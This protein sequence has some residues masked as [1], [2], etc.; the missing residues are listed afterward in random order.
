[1]ASAVRKKY[2]QYCLMERLNEQD[3]IFALKLPHVESPGN[4]SAG[5]PGNSDII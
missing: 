5:A 2:S 3:C 1:M 4:P